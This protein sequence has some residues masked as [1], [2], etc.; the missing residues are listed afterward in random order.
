ME[1]LEQELQ[2]KNRAFLDNNIN[3]PTGQTMTLRDI[4]GS[5]ALSL[6]SGKLLTGLV[7]WG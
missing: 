6:L 7:D 3:R 2:N 5:G 1:K 4:T